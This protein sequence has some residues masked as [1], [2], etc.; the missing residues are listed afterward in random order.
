MKDPGDYRRG[1]TASSSVLNAI[2]FVTVRIHNDLTCLI[3][4]QQK[5]PFRTRSLN[6][7]HF[8]AERNTSHPSKI[9]SL[10]DGKFSFSVP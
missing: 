7:F 2:Y 10:A 6:T 5:F 9:C 3:R 1:S 4:R 8:A